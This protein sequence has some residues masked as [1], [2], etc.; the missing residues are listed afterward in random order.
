M[1]NIRPV[2]ATNKHWRSSEEAMLYPSKTSPFV[3][4]TAWIRFD[5]ATNKQWESKV[6]AWVDRSLDERDH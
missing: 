4:C 2:I 3:C 5:L 6:E 1:R